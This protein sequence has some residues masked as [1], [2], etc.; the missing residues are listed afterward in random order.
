ME[1]IYILRK[2]RNIFRPTVINPLHWLYPHGLH[3]PHHSIQMCNS[4]SL[5]SPFWLF[6][7]WLPHQAHPSG[8][9]T[10]YHPT[11]LIQNSKLNLH[12]WRTPSDS[13]REQVK[14]KV[15]LWRQKSMMESNCPYSPYVFFTRSE[16]PTRV[17]HN[18]WSIEIE[19][20]ISYTR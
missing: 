10:Q 7:V 4:L 17:K 9:P 18:T 12:P 19:S 6:H 15:I 8:G 16:I 11:A 14:R 20:L 13:V 5:L 3:S 1:Y 2:I